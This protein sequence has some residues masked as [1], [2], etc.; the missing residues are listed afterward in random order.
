M[1]FTTRPL[2]SWTRP[3][4]FRSWA[5]FSRLTAFPINQRNIGTNINSELIVSILG[6]PNAG[7]STLFNRLMCKELNRAYR[8][9]S[10]KKGGKTRSQ[11]SYLRFIFLT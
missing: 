9:G 4:T 7:K 11:A 2:F 3:N 1:S 10:E 8:L 5:G 6:P